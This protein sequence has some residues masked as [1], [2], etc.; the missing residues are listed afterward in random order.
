ML[1]AMVLF[2]R[3]R[4]RSISVPQVCVL[5]GDPITPLHCRSISLVRETTEPLAMLASSLWRQFA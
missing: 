1:T 5:L 3:A 4:H 2:N